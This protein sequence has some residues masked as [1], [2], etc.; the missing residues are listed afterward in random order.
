MDKFF[1]WLHIVDLGEEPSDERERQFFKAPNGQNLFRL[2][3]KV[4]VE[5]HLNG[6][7]KAS[8]T[9]EITRGPL[10]MPLFISNLSVE[11]ILLQFNAPH[12]QSLAN[13]ILNKLFGPRRRPTLKGQDLFGFSRKSVT[14]AIDC[15]KNKKHK[16]AHT[17]RWGGVVSYGSFN[18]SDGSEYIHTS[19]SKMLRLQP[20]YEAIQIIKLKNNTQPL[21]LS[22]KISRGSTGPLY[23]IESLDDPNITFSNSKPTVSM[24]QMFSHF[25]IHNTRNGSGFDFFGLM[26]SEVLEK[27]SEK[28]V[29]LKRSHDQI[30]SDPVIERLKRIKHRNAGPT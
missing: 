9:C 12:P 14:N 2:G 20:G 29:D 24:R 8:R 10:A 21:K 26:R 25:E 27:L 17:I 7:G 6:N 15:L 22:L 13:Q 23:T 5:F 3:Y 16:K 28:P 18:D 1:Q 30:Q 11:S 4:A 19:G